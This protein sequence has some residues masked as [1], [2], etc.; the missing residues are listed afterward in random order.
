MTEIPNICYIFEQLVVQGCQKWYSGLSDTQIHKYKYANTLPRYPNTN[1]KIHKYTNTALVKVE[2]RHNIC[3]IF[4]KV[5]ERGLQTNIHEYLMY[6]YKYINTQTHKYGFESNISGCPTCRYT[7]IFVLIFPMNFRSARTSWNTSVRSSVRPSVRPQEKSKSLPKPF[8]TSKD[9]ARPL[10][11]SMD[12]K[13]TMYSII[14][15]FQ[16][17]RQRQIQGQRQKSKFR[18]Y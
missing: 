9:P 1:M 10:K 16:I 13:R 14:Q 12:V 15:W 3:Y 2:H 6:K 5:I 11:W 7:N 4:E 17:Q 8:K 18:K